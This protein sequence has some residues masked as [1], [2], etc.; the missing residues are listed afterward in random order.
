MI[1]SP[2]KIWEEY[3]RAS[4]G[5]KRRIWKE[6][7]D[8]LFHE[9]VPAPF[10]LATSLLLDVK[11]TEKENIDSIMT[12][13]REIALDKAKDSAS[14]KVAVDFIR[15]NSYRE[16]NLKGNIYSFDTLYE[17]LKN[18]KE[19]IKLRML[20]GDALIQ[21]GSK[22]LTRRI[23]GS[24]EL[25]TWLEEK[26]KE[27][28]RAI[29]LKDMIKTWEETFMMKNRDAHE[30]FLAAIL[31]SLMDKYSLLNSDRLLAF[32]KSNKV[33]EIEDRILLKWREIVLGRL[34]GLKK[35][36]TVD[37]IKDVRDELSFDELQK[38]AFEK[39]GVLKEAQELAM[40][41]DRGF[42]EKEYKQRD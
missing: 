34:E 41:F 12:K 13:V 31:L 17:I 16:K 10:I 28:E 22:W 40:K 11:D 35:R 27:T 30:R 14:R 7:T 33:F 37:D 32:L 23:T 39:P 9:K 42:F 1:R 24:E 3:M 8:S 6:V 29:Y 20:A 25:L 19:D 2:S 26:R 18:E 21:M 36:W 4:S 5:E 15:I 38:I